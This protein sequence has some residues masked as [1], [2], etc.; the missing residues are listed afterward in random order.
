MEL[1]QTAREAFV[2]VTVLISKTWEEEPQTCD[3]GK[4]AVACS[5]SLEPRLALH[6]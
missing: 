2:L 4:P 5:G 3:L 1:R 6:S